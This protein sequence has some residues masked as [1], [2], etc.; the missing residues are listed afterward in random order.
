MP[1]FIGLIPTHISLA[2]YAQNYNIFAAN[3]L[4]SAPTDFSDFFP[5]FEI[6]RFWY[7]VSVRNPKVWISNILKSGKRQKP[8]AILLSPSVQTKIRTWVLGQIILWI[9]KLN[10][11]G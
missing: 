9:K 1:F 3:Q 11:L 7:T 8:D 5:L 2:N 4:P 10:G 6:T